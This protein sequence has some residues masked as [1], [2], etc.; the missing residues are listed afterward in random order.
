M[1]E[2]FLA[3]QVLQ[4][5]DSAYELRAKKTFLLGI[6]QGVRK[7]VGSYLVP[8]SLD[9]F[10]DGRKLLRYVTQYKEGSFCT[11]IIQNPEQLVAGR[12]YAVFESV[13]LSV[14]NLQSLIPIFKV[15]GQGIRNWLCSHL[16]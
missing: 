9:P 13:L 15:D 2:N 5:S 8:G 4:E 11:G 16:S 1:A 12:F 10:Y 7:S 6:D 14:R 3:R